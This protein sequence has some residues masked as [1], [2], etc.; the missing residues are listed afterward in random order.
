[1]LSGIMMPESASATVMTGNGGAMK[2]LAAITTG[3]LVLVLCYMTEP[4]RAEEQA[5]P[6]VAASASLASVEARTATTF[7]AE[8][9]HHGAQLAAVGD[10]MVCHT[11]QGGKP[12]AGGLPIHTPFGTIFTTNITPDPDTGI[13]GWSLEAFTRAMH[14]GVSRDGH[15][16]YPAFPYP[17]FTHMSD[18][19]IAAIYAFIMSRDPVR[20]VPPANRLTFPL[21]FRPLI[22]GWNFFYLHRGELAPDPAQNAEWNRGRYLVN[23]PAHCAACHSPMNALGAE[24]SDQPFGGGKVDGWEAPALTRLL[25]APTPWTHAQLVSYLRTGLASE[26][27]AAAGPMEPVTHQLA[28]VPDTDIKAMATYLMSLQMPA[29]SASQ[30][31]RTDAGSG[32]G[33]GVGAG[34]G[35]G[36]GAAASAPMAS[37]NGPG[38]ALF[39]A[40][41]ASCHGT[42]SPMQALGERPSLSQ[43]TAVNADSP[44]NAVRIILDGIGWKGSEAAHYMPAFA[45]M[46]T[47]AQLADIANYMRAQYSPQEPWP[48]LDE[49]A[50]ARLRGDSP[51]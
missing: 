5:A 17:H 31:P 7:P 1:M 30:S 18:G 50:V 42:G 6:P 3:L 13:G 8:T 21:N 23:G 32:V 20:A 49:A 12:F 41:C 2:G 34:A 39:V 15:L 25:H 27:G 11:A 10:C 38:K 24:K 4:L 45:T 28:D 40:A 48:D 36:A 46:F 29:P 51:K 37:A 16:L 47:D 44:R 14:E 35:A 43:S 22:A 9:L 33:V 26:H 19:D